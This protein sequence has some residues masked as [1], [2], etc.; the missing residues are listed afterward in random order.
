MADGKNKLEREDF[1]PIIQ[2][3]H[4]LAC[5]QID[6]LELFGDSKRSAKEYAEAEERAAS[7]VLAAARALIDKME[8]REP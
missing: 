7:L 3:A 1:A 5:I 2:A 4:T 8:G 6:A